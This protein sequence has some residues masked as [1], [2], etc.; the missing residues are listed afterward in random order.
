MDELVERAGARGHGAR[1]NM[2]FNIDAEEADR[3]DLSLDVIEAMLADPRL[4][5][6]DGFGVVVQPTARA[7]AMSS[8]GSRR[9]PK[10]STG[11]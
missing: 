2:G 3:L 11:G 10:S 4:A 6:W 1:A 5:G 8:T 7:P 9:S